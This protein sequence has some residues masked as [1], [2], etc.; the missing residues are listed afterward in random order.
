LRNF[1]AEGMPGGPFRKRSAD[2]AK[3][4]IAQAAVIDV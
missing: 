2:R 3:L 1:H 4:P